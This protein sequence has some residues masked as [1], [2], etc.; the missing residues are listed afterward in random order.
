MKIGIIVG[1]TREGN[2]GQVVGKWLLQ[3]AQTRKHTY[4]LL[5]VASFKLP[6]LGEGNAKENIQRWQEKIKSMDGYIFVA[7]EY[8]HSL[9][10]SLKN[11]LDLV[12][13]PWANKAAGVVS[14]GYAGGA[15]AAE[16]LRTILG[17]LAVADVQQHVMFN[18]NTEFHPK[19][20]FKPAAYQIGLLGKLFDQVERWSEGLLKSRI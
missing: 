12:L 6:L 2:V 20:G 8:N 9:T 16:H 1:S 19:E 4:E 10:A 18:L 3:Q 11:A 14:Y 13:E 5:E 17:A 15:R 7:A